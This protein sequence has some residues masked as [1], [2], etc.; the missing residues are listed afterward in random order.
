MEQIAFSVD[1]FEPTHAPG[2]AIR[3]SDTGY[4]VLGQ[5]LE[6]DT[7][8]SLP[9]VVAELCRFDELG[10]ATPGGSAT[11]RRRFRCRRAS[12][13]IG[14]ND[15]ENVD[16]SIDLYGGGGMVSSVDDLTTWWRALFH[17]EIV[18]TRTLAAMLSPLAPSTES[19]G[20]CG[21]G[22]FRRN[23]AGRTW[24]THSGYWGSIV[25]HDP[26]ADLTLTA[27]RNQSELRTAA[28][29]PLL[30]SVLDAMHPAG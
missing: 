1:R 29:E 25:L 9:E 19:H 28:L 27:F 7:G 11:S 18:E 16:C 17:N 5:L 30:A 4:V 24:W 21:L 2:T 26:G 3:Y 14:D 6:H 10:L 8:T 12:V 13:Q 23:V 15:W 22:L 20:D